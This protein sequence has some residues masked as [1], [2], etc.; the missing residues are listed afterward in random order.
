MD[1]I[2]N[3][4]VTITNKAWLSV[5]ITQSAFVANVLALI[6]VISPILG[7]IAGIIGVIIGYYSLRIK[8]KEW[9]DKNHKR[10]IHPSHK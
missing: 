4:I 8:Y 1:S 2:T 6:G 10:K 9:K 5:A 3:T 7:F